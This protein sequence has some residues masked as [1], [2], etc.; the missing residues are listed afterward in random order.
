MEWLHNLNRQIFLQINAAVDASPAL[1]SAATFVAEDLVTLMFTALLVLFLW[2]YRSDK[3]LI[4]GVLVSICCAVAMTYLIRK[5]VDSPRP[6]MVGVGTNFLP[7]SASSSFPSKHATP[8]F[9]AAA[10]LLLYAKTR[11]IA[12]IWLAL[13]LAVAWSRIY[14]GVHWPLDMLGAAVVGLC[15]AFI[16]KG[17]VRNFN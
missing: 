8:V 7:H 4:V 1:I 6:F 5:G 16:A 2:R 15:G 3:K 17:A 12:V 13:T 9:A 14:L 10:F 11:G